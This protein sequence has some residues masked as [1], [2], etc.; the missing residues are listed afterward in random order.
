MSGTHPTLY[1][2]LDDII[3]LADCEVYS[4]VPD[5]ESDPLGT[6]YTDDEDGTIS[7]GEE[8]SSADDEDALFQ[9]DDY[10]VDEA[11]KDYRGR[12][13][14]LSSSRSSSGRNRMP[15]RD[16]G[17]SPMRIRI[18]RKGALL[19]SSHW[20]F[21]NRKMRRILFISICA[22][23]RLGQRWMSDDDVSYVRLEKSNE[24]FLGW[25]GAEGAGARAFGIAIKSTPLVA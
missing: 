13:S 12:S 15:E 24:R 20:F 19:W 9:F 1:R 7:A 18:R 11:S 14:R 3:G 5:I 6:D 8:E 21:H 25:D 22:R 17:G 4:Y 10:D 23:S 16:E 2:L